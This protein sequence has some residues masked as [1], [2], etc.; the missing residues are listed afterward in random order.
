MYLKNFRGIASL[1]AVI[2]LFSCPVL[3]GCPGNQGDCE[4]KCCESE[5]SCGHC[6]AAIVQQDGLSSE[7][8]VLAV[9]VPVGSSNIPCAAIY[10]P[11]VIAPDLNLVIESK[12]HPHTGPPQIYLTTIM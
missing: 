4:R 5:M 10:I 1:L 12:I 9:T 2:C 6:Q 8:P 11:L 7:L 3:A